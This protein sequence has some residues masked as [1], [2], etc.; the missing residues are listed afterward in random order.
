MNLQHG[1]MAVNGVAVFSTYGVPASEQVSLAR[2]EKQ[3]SP[4]D[5]AEVRSR[6]RQ[7]DFRQSMLCSG[8]SCLR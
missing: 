8:T 4:I 2:R 7:A 1:P 6:Y 5:R 3:I